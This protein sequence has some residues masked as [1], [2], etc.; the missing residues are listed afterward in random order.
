MY[1]KTEECQDVTLPNSNF[2]SFLFSIKET[3]RGGIIRGSFPGNQ[4]K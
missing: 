1:Q 3:D 2:I 4:F